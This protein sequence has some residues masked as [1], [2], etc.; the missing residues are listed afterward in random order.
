MKYR[1]KELVVF[2]PHVFRPEYSEAWFPLEHT[3]ESFLE[4]G[5]SGSTVT[6]QT[7]E[8]AK[9]FIAN[10]KQDLINAKEIAEENRPIIHEDV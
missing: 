3:W 9:G 5:N 6:F 10:H 2:N 8:G 4:W 7:L 1:V